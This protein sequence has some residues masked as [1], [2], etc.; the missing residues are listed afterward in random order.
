MAVTPEQMIAAVEAHGSFAAAARALGCGSQVVARTWVA[1]GREPPLKQGQKYKPGDYKPEPVSTIVP[2][3]D[4]L[5]DP[6]MPIEDILAYREKAFD[7]K[8]AHHS[9]KRWRKFKVPNAGPYA[10]MF[11]GDPHVDDD[12]CHLPLLRAHCQLAAETPNLY[13]INIGD[14]TNN[15]AGRLARLWAE[16][17]ASAA[18]A[19]RLA[20]WLLIDSGVPWWLWLHGNHDAWDGPVGIPWYE[21][22]KPHYVTMEDWQAKVTLVSPCGREIR[23][24]AAHNFKGTSQWNPLHGPLKAAQMG[25]WA[26][27]YVAGHHHNWGVM[28]GEHDHRGFIYNIAR[29]RGFKFIDS[30]ADHNGFGCHQYGAAPVA[31]I[32]PEGDKPNAVTVFNDAFEGAEFLA[33]KR[34]K[35]AA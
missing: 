7:R 19:R 21:A 25:D 8:L 32:D 10:L 13:A 27:L 28:Q 15:W 31:V 12:G 20:Q 26:H 16:Q 3:A 23:L 5:P 29:A 33:W 14:S 17:D 4:P 22:K 30:Y 24:W 35:L 34:R 6:D 18:T 2:I 1:A 9:A 11:F